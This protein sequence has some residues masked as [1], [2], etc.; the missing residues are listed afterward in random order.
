MPV[1][2]SLINYGKAKRNKFKGSAKSPF[3]SKRHGVPVQHPYVSS[4]VIHIRDDS[5]S[6]YQDADEEF[7]TK[8]SLDSQNERQRLA[9]EPLHLDISPETLTSWFP[10]EFIKRDTRIMSR[11]MFE[12]QAGGS[13]M[14]EHEKGEEGGRVAAMDKSGRLEVEEKVIENDDLEPE[15]GNA[16]ELIAKLQNMHASSFVGTPNSAIF[17]SNISNRTVLPPQNRIPTPLKIPNSTNSTTS[18]IQ[19][20]RGSDI[21]R[22]DPSRPV[23]EVSSVASSAVSGTTLARA[24]ISNTFVL[25]I[26]TRDLQRHRSGISHLGRTDSATLPTGEYAYFNSPHGRERRQ[27]GSGEGSTPW[28]GGVDDVPPVPPM[29]SE[30]ELL[31]LS[32]K[33]SPQSGLY[34]NK[35][36]ALGDSQARSSTA[37]LDSLVSPD[38]STRVA[39]SDT[40]VTAVGPVAAHRISRVSE[41]TNSA[42]GTPTPVDRNEVESV[43]DGGPVEAMQKSLKLPISE[44][45]Q[46]EYDEGA[47]KQSVVS[48]SPASPTIIDHTGNV[49][50][51]KDLDNVIDYYV[52]SHDTPQKS[53]RLD[54]S[55][56][57]EVSEPS[58]QFSPAMTS[59]GTRRSQRCTIMIPFTPSPLSSDFVASRKR[60]ESLSGMDSRK[61][62][63]L[64]IGERRCSSQF[65]PGASSHRNSMSLSS[66]T[67]E[68]LTPP[69]ISE[70]FGRKRSGSAPSPIVVVRDFKD[71]RHD[72]TLSP[73]T[74]NIGTPLMRDDFIMQTFPETPDLTSPGWTPGPASSSSFTR[75]LR[76]AEIQYPS[77][78][79]TPEPTTLTNFS[80]IQASFAQT[81]LLARAASSVH[82]SRHSRQSSLA[83]NRQIFMLGESS[84]MKTG[85]VQEAG[86]QNGGNARNGEANTSSINNTFHEAPA[87]ASSGGSSSSIQSRTGSSNESASHLTTSSLSQSAEHL[88]RRE[89]LLETGPIPSAGP[90]SMSYRNEIANLS[91][92]AVDAHLDDSLNVSQSGRIQLDHPRPPELVET[93]S[94]PQSPSLYTAY[95]LTSLRPILSLNP[96]SPLQQSSLHAVAR[97]H[98]RVENDN[99]SPPPYDAV[100]NDRLAGDTGT[101]NTSGFDLH[102][103][104]TYRN[105]PGPPPT[106]GSHESLVIGSTNGRRARPRPR[107]PAGPRERRDGRGLS[108]V[109]DRNGSISSVSSTLP[110]SGVTVRQN[111]QTYSPEF[112]VA[113]PKWK[114]LTMEAAKWT[115]TSAE[116]Q[117]IVSRAIR[118]SAETSSIR[119]LRLETLDNDIPE[120]LRRLEAEQRDIKARYKHLSERRTKLL[121]SLFYCFNTQGSESPGSSFRVIETLKDISIQMDNLAECLHN[122]D[123]Q[124]AQLNLLVLKH[125]GSALSMALRK[126]NTS[127]LDRLAQL[128]QTRQEVVQLELERDE[129]QRQLE[130]CTQK[131]PSSI[132]AA[133]ILRKNSSRR[134]KA[135]LHS[136]SRRSSYNSN[137]LSVGSFHPPS[138]RSPYNYDDI[139]PV[140]PVPPSSR[141]GDI[142]TDISVHSAIP[143][144]TAVPTPSTSALREQEEL[145]VDIERRIGSGL[146][147]SHS[148]VSFSTTDGASH[149]VPPPPTR[150]RHNTSRSGRPTSL[151]DGV[152]LSDAY[153]L[154]NADSTAMLVTLRMLSDNT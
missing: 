137:R 1:L 148:F 108:S 64:P 154:M 86:Y 31:Y 106:A 122:A 76:A 107:L 3:A 102:Y 66:I 25:S 79:R 87:L 93:L 118:Q 54:I 136:C 132:G 145:F 14:R 4:S 141:P 43:A 91:Q 88:W 28:S 70:I 75:V 5:T 119:L 6:E 67:M 85:T 46:A 105:S 13:G 95:P 98:I 48:P 134:F 99:E 22:A 72:V 89:P 140:P 69:P 20:R 142:Y 12:I 94:T 80:G 8:S 127:F 35:R 120:E 112:R 109:R 26:D 114:G 23:S 144:P 24:L 40:T 52:A 139:P 32:N 124:I 73:G 83:R 126:L 63:P 104:Q 101:P 61:K 130:E 34:M 2:P 78:P 45:E 29:P 47:D 133:G 125:S 152:P 81:V 82:G 92:S 65:S 62:H 39:S 96:P 115:F 90:A 55:P 17:P 56:I 71:L 21:T 60:P 97:L 151:P 58:S 37:G 19:M 103:P 100:F 117:G 121:D 111:T 131:A 135:G 138:A 116:L 49:T 51:P 50:S 42:P 57:T 129:T 36:R 15:E 84:I 113:S 153:K 123:E 146:R 147:R 7:A 149:Q 44:V 33:L 30:A 11:D 38:F 59:S 150:S 53:F 74:N 110:S 9:Y 68:A 41:A 18:K 10:P 128:E 77:F 16:N 27:S 143:F